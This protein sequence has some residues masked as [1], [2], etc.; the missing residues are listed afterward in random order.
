MYSYLPMNATKF[1][2]IAND[3]FLLC[4]WINLATLVRTKISSWISMRLLFLSHKHRAFGPKYVHGS[5][6]PRTRSKVQQRSSND[7][8]P[9]CWYIGVGTSI[10]TSTGNAAVPAVADRFEALP[11]RAMHPG[12][13]ERVRDRVERPRKTV[14]PRPISWWDPRCRS[15]NA[16]RKCKTI[17][18]D[19]EFFYS[20]SS[21]FFS[22]FFFESM[23]RKL[24]F[25]GNKDLTRCQVYAKKYF[26]S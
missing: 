9:R 14:L 16:T 10:C 3:T 17:V 2:P 13:C 25:C 23:V 19:V 4:I 12:Y 6:K 18:I 21:F 15:A 24:K 22:F 8:V 5:T 20:F 26:F 1:I 11:L 7:R